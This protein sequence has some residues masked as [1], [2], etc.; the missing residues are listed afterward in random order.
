MLRSFFRN[1]NQKLMRK[2]KKTQVAEKKKAKTPQGLGYAKQLSKKN[3][4]KM[5]AAA[6][7]RKLFTLPTMHDYI[8]NE[9]DVTEFVNLEYK[10]RPNHIEHYNKESPNYIYSEVDETS[11]RVDS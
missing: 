8:K 2:V 4:E 6:N 7:S 10:K 1:R 3:I 11:L 9:V 5:Q